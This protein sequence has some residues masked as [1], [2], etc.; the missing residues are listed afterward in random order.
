MREKGA[1]ENSKGECKRRENNKRRKRP[2]HTD[3]LSYL[4]APS[5]TVVEDWLAN[6]RKHAL[7]PAPFPAVVEDVGD[8]FVK[9]FLL[10]IQ[11]SL[12][13]DQAGPRIHSES[14]VVC[15]E[16]TNEQELIG[17]EKGRKEGKEEGRE[18][19]R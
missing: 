9:I 1:C 5:R 6:S 7:S 10:A 18:V 11:G 3:N 4:P 8:E 12:G 19:G 13:H 17:G 15:R 14:S 2:T 16:F